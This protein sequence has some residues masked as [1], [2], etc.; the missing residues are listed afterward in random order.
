M[1]P[2]KKKESLVE[3]MPEVTAVDEFLL[4][5]NEKFKWGEKVKDLNV[6]KSLYSDLFDRGLIKDASV[7]SDEVLTAVIDYHKK[8]R[9]KVKL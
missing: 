4:Q 1:W 6:D 7:G 5:L 3:E 2:F 9:I 8:V